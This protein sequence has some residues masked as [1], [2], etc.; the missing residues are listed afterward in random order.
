MRYRE[1]IGFLLQGRLKDLDSALRRLKHLIAD[2]ESRVTLME[3]KRPCRRDAAMSSPTDAYLRQVVTT[4]QP[5][6]PHFA[7]EALSCGG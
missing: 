5:D 3:R 4:E 7:A 1:N 6:R 2:V